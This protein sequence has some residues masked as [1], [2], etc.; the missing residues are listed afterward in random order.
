MGTA[1]DCRALRLAISAFPSSVAVLRRVDETAEGGLLSQFQ[2]FSP[3]A[4]P[5]PRRR[6]HE[7]GAHDQRCGGG[8]FGTAEPSV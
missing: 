2:P 7:T 1:R 6:N 3:P 8:T 5:R 4:R